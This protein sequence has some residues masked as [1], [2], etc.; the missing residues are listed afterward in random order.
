MVEYFL[1]YIEQFSFRIS[2]IYS[3]P[4]G[5]KLGRKGGKRIFLGGRIL[6]I[7]WFFGHVAYMQAADF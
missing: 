5:Q 1:Y 4:V 2:L 6:M 3:S 7:N